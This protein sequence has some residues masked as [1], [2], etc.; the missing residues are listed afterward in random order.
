MS[1]VS[2]KRKNEVGRSGYEA[3]SY[4]VILPQPQGKHLCQTV[5]TA[6]E[7]VREDGF[8]VTKAKSQ[9]DTE[10]LPPPSEVRHC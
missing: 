8:Q 9:R 7:V 6:V 1:A 2:R 10:V 4:L 5:T 3:G